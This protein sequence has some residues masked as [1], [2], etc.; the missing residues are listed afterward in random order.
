VALAL[1]IMMALMKWMALV[2]WMALV[3]LAMTLTA[4][5]SWWRRNAPGGNWV[6]IENEEEAFVLAYLL[7]LSLCIVGHSSTTL[8]QRAHSFLDSSS[9]CTR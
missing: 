3:A 8:W 2:R 9:E 7:E 5:F 6:E 4:A 1:M